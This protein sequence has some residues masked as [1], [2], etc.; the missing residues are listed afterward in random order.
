MRTY[1]VVITLWLAVCSFVLWALLTPQAEAQDCGVKCAFIATA[2]PGGGPTSPTPTDTLVI[3]TDTLTSTVTPFNTATQGPTATIL[4]SST[5]MPTNT[6]GTPV[7]C[8][9]QK[10]GGFCLTF[11]PTVTRTPVPANTWVEDWSQGLSRW[12]TPSCAYSDGSILHSTCGQIFSTQHWD[13]LQPV[14]ITGTV[15]GQ[16]TNSYFCG[17]VIM[18]DGNIYGQTAIGRDID[19]TRFGSGISGDVFYSNEYGEPDGQW[20]NYYYVWPVDQNTWQSF[21]LRLTPA[22]AGIDTHATWTASINGVEQP[23]I[24]RY[25]LTSP[26]RIDLQ[27]Q[28]QGSGECQFGSLIVTGVQV[29]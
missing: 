15:R 14:T 12:G 28:P 24:Q 27:G 26:V 3:A 29:P 5:P 13:Q 2:T 22:P 9:Y 8:Y 18:Q 1:I 23:E 19:P 4:L 6:V 7:G 17:L 20:F 21:V 11:T 10:V 25:Q 16:T